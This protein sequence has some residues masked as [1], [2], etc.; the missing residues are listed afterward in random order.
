MTTADPADRISALVDQAWVLAAAAR[1][2]FRDGDGQPHDLRTAAARKAV[3]A[4][5]LGLPAGDAALMFARGL[6]AELAQMLALAD[7]TADVAW[8]ELDEETLLGQGRAS[9]ANIG[10]MLAP[11]GRHPQSCVSSLRH[12]TRSSLTSGRESVRSVRPCAEAGRH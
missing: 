11:G 8:A 5:H 9:G 6:R 7:P 10:A 3:E 4:A 1:V 12:R 2:M